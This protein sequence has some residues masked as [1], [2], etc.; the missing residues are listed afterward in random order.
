MSNFLIRQIPTPIIIFIGFLLC[1][2]TKKFSREEREFKRYLAETFNRQPAS[3]GENVT[4]YVINMN[5]CESCIDQHFLAVHSAK[6]KQNTI[7]IIVGKVLKK[8]WNQ[9]LNDVKNR[10]VNVLIDDRGEGLLYYFGLV[11]PIILKFESSKL[12][13]LIRIE[14]NEVSSVLLA[15]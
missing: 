15:L 4:Y 9:I 11:K 6:F 13:D 14:D 7:L 2:S 10:G 1:C 12:V 8:E 5:A 3:E